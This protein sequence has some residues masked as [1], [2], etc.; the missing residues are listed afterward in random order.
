MLKKIV[1]LLALLLF[2]KDSSANECGTWLTNFTS[3]VCTRAKYIF[4]TGATL[5]LGLRVFKEIQGRDEIQKRAKNKNHLKGLGREAGELGKGYLNAA[6]FLG[7]LVLGGNKGNERAE[8]MLE[9]SFYTVGMT[10]GLKKSIHESRPGVPEDPDSFP[11]GHSSASFAFASVVTAQHGWA[12]G[13]GAHLIATFVS[14]SRL[15]DDWHYLHDVIA[16]M[17]IGM[18]YGWGIYFN[19]KDHNKP[20]WLSLS[21]TPDLSGLTLGVSA[22][23]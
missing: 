5:T 13:A 19:H 12:W 4:W 2:I 20:Y 21:P 17:T 22:S 11:S 9:A 7:Q 1:I 3:P 23:F 16:G 6:Y 15:N 10:L 14:F 18:S 8:H